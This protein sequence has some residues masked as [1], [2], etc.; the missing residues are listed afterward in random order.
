MTTTQPV[1]EFVANIGDASPIEHGGL[2]VYRDKTG[3]Y[4][5]E[6]ERCDPMLDG[7]IEIRR[8]VLEPCTFID[9]I[10]SN[11]KFHPQL[12]AWFAGD[13]NNPTEAL[14]AMADTMDRT[15]DEY[16]ALFTSD[17]PLER[18][19]AWR[20]VGDFFGWDNLDSYPHTITAD[21]A[22]QRYSKELA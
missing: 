11:N 14:R 10:L 21:E 12:V 17:C 5:P 15:V 20:D 8:A 7:T 16:V 6:M 13:R 4:P 1:W 19:E 18:A 9:G 2:F 3:V 22:A